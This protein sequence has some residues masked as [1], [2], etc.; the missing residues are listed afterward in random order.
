MNAF[1]W[2][3]ATWILTIIFLLPSAS[4]AFE[5]NFKEGQRVEVAGTDLTITVNQVRDLT[6]QGCLGGPVACPDQAQLKV[7][8]GQEH[9]DIVLSR[10]NVQ[11]QRERRVNQTHIF[12]YTITLT[13]LKGKNITLK[14]NKRR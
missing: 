13:M 8:R 9:K 1:C 12:G 7:S 11:I 3:V 10:A 14:I 2:A 6:S 4:E 5:I